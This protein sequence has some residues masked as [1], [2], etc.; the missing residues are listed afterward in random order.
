MDGPEQREVTPV[1]KNITVYFD[2]PLS[3]L[4]EDSLIYPAREYDKGTHPR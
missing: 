2:I 3:I 4:F 1:H